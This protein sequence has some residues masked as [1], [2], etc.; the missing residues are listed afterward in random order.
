MAP[1]V[2][3]AG[4]TLGGGLGW[5]SRSHG[6]ASGSIVAIDAVD[7]RGRAIRIDADHHPDLFWAARGGIAPVV[8]TALE[9]RLY[10][11]AQLW[12][13][14]LMWPLDRAADVAHT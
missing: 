11:I 10:P 8:V 9:L 13:G 1:S 4:Y 14:A 2:G 12:A 5:L 3:V 7:A 6:L